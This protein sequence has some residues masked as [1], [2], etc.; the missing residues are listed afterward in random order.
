MK[1]T[2]TTIEIKKSDHVLT[3][4]KGVQDDELVVLDLNGYGNSP[5]LDVVGPSNAQNIL[6]DDSDFP[7]HCTGNVKTLFYSNVSNNLLMT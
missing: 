6:V 7:C 2:E 3:L 5:Q 4:L 1:T